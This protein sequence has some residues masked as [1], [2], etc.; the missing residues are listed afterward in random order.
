MC[1]FCEETHEETKP[2]PA[3]S[4]AQQQAQIKLG[5]A[6]EEAGELPCQ[7]FPDLFFPDSRATR[8]HSDS[9]LAKKMCAECPIIRECGDYAIRYEEEGIWGG[10][11]KP[12][13]EKLSG[14]RA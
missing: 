11:T 10:L 1:E 7:N 3:F 4:Y 8:Q 6:V 14:R 12:E 2:K 5:Q 9:A 13:R